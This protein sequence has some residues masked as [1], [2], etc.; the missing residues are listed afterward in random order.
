M[1]IVL[2]NI[3]FSYQDHTIFKNCDCQFL[4]GKINYLI[5]YNGSG[6]STLFD[7]ISGVQKVNNGTIVSSIKTDEIVYQT[8]NPIF[9][10][11]LNG[12]DL[13]QFIFGIATGYQKIEVNQLSL[14]FKKLY[15]DLMNRKLGSMSVGEKR[16]LLIFLENFLQKNVFLLD[17][18]TSGVDPVAN[19]QI[20][21]QLLTLAQDPH[22]LVIV[23]THDLQHLVEADCYIHLLSNQKIRTFND[24]EGFMA[25]AQKSDPEE[26]FAVLT[27]N[28]Q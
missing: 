4:P 28:E 26:A 23:T 3:S 19:R 7:L 15:S 18:P 27:G 25:A 24:F 13:K 2:D 9:F 12:N 8:Q 17:E 20:N 5:G 14:H 21:D 16:W 22:K 10:G 6:K 11:S 1:K